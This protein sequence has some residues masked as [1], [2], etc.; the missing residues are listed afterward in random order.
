MFASLVGG[1]GVF[2]LGMVLMTDGLKAVAG[3]ALKRILTKY[4]GTA[5]SGVGW[6]ALVTALILSWTATTLTP[7]GFISAGLLT[8]K[9]ALGVIFG[10]NL[11]TTSTGWIVSQL[12]FKVSLGSIS[13]P[14]VL[15]GVAM[16][17][18]FRG[19]AGHVGI[20]LA[21]FALLF[22]GIEMVQAGMGSVASRLNP[23]AFPGGGDGGVLS[24]LLLVVLGFLMTVVMLSSSAAMTTTLAAV[25][26]GAIGL[27]QAA[28]LVIGQNI[29]TTPKAVAAAIGAPAAAK[30]TAVG[31]VLF[32]VLTG[33][34]AMTILPWL[35]RASTWTADAV[36]SGDA[37]TILALFHTVFNVLGVVLVFPVIGPFARLIE[38]IVPDRGPR[39]TRYL[40]PAVAEVGPVALEATRRAMVHV[41]MDLATALRQAVAGSARHNT[42]RVTSEAERGLHEIIRFVHRLGQSTQAV[43]ELNRKQALL[44]AADHMERL[45]TMLPSPPQEAPLAGD[46]VLAPAVELAGAAPLSLL[47]ARERAGR[48]E[49]LS[50]EVLAGVVREAEDASKRLADVRKSQRRET[51]RQAAAGA[52]GPDAAMARVD[53][54]VWLDSL[55]YHFWRAAHHLQPEPA[56]SGGSGHVE[57]DGSPLVANHA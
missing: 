18:L 12:G 51:L 39:A 41:L 42:A 45:I 36:G 13:P 17:L 27:E 31:H 40:A 19:R 35:L 26:S 34:I 3:D 1:L 50:S 8:L 48:D 54:L 11:G 14:L 28:A 24:T 52:M 32:N 22:M 49:T 9:Q 21:G 44:H 38:R 56:P 25:A 23:Q 5:A 43:S 7:V 2:L 10:A 29:G 47:T 6:G 57:T 46:G 30:R 33:A 55:A 16:R 4:V 37:P 20:A 15:V 53:G